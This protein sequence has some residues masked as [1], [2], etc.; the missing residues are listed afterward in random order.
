MGA[1][2][3]ERC[4]SLAAA[5]G[6]LVH[7]AFTAGA[8]LGY[9]CAQHASYVPSRPPAALPAPPRPVAQWSWPFN[10]PVDLKQYP[11]YAETIKTPMDFGTIKRWVVR[12]RQ[13]ALRS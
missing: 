2:R 11:D 13:P 5:G 9:S 10:A 12:G 7:A 3:L 6:C 8:H 1:A 4:W